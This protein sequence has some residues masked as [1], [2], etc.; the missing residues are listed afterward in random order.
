MENKKAQLGLGTVKAV[1][2]IFLVLGVLAVSIAIIMPLLRDAAET[3]DQVTT[4]TTNVTTTAVVNEVGTF[5]TGTNENSRACSLSITEAYFNVSQGAGGDGNITEIASGNY[6]IVGCRLSYSI[7]ADEDY[8]INNTLWNVTG[9]YTLADSGAA[10]IAG[11]ITG[12]TKTFFNSTGTIFAILVVVVII[13]AIAIIVAV[14][15]RFG[16]GATTTGGGAFGG[17][18]REFGAGTVGGV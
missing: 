17:G 16:G 5:V 12:G 2:I 10:D 9:S 18:R 13:L 11:N 7:T 8:G 14:V 1:M 6:T 3:I 15:S 4:E